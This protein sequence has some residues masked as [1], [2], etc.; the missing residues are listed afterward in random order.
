M[1]HFPGLPPYRLPHIA[2][3]LRAAA[4]FWPEELVFK[5]APSR[6]VGP[7]GAVVTW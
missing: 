3:P 2:S 6:L 7:D 1:N 5:D 4:V